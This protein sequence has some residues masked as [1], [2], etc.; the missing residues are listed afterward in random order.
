MRR[1]QYKVIWVVLVVI[2][3]GFWGCTREKD[4][5]TAP[6]TDSGTLKQASWAANMSCTEYNNPAATSNDEFR[7]E[8]T[9]VEQR[10]NLLTFTYQV[11]KLGNS[12]E[13]K[14]L[15]HWVL[16]LD[17]FFPYLA[18]NMTMSDLYVNCGILDTSGDGT[19]GLTVL[20]PSTQMM[21]VKF[22]SLSMGD[23]QCQSYLVT[24]DE[25]ALARGF[26]IGTDSIVVATKAG[27]QDVTNPD[28]AA[29][30][31]ACVAG[32]GVQEAAH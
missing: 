22:D 13:V 1:F 2:G 29:P 32:P 12:P 15:R 19:C 11:C 24:L 17:Q 10:G 20:D 28:A 26:Q 16:G 14:N 25:T 31:F 23:G 7:I 5:V 4:T 27:N 21:G 3:L 18:E 6:A 8:L 9:Q 30:G